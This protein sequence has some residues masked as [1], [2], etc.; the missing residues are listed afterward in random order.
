MGS[1]SKT[2]LVWRLFFCGQI[3]LM[4]LKEVILYWKESPLKA[5]PSEAYKP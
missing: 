1:R 2:L 5:P 4:E 3:D